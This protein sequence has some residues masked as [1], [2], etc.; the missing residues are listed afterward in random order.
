MELAWGF[1]QDTGI[2]LPAENPGT[3]ADPGVAVLPVEGQRAPGPELVQVRQGQRQLRPADR[4]GRLPVRQ[5]LDARPGGHR[6]DRP[7][8][9]LGHAAAAGP[10]LRGA[11]QRRHAVQPADRRGADQPDG[12]VVQQDHAAGGRAPAGLQV[13]RSP[14]SGSALAGRGHQRHRGGDVRRLPA[15]QG[16][17]GGQD[18][19]RPGSRQP[20]HLGV[21]LVR[22]VRPPQVRRGH[23]DPEL[24]FRRGRLR[25]GGPADLGRRSTA[26]RATRRRCRAATCPACR[27]LD[28]AGQLVPRQPGFGA[29]RRRPEPGKAGRRRPGA[30][31]AARRELGAAVQSRRR[32]YAAR[33]GRAR[34][35]AG[36]PRQGRRAATRRSG[37][38]TGCCS[39]RCSRSPCSGRC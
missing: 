10:G 22:A 8:L 9:R 26:W 24:R 11:G 13:A 38:P 21:R 29:G 17:R 27:T 23:D 6:L 35:S 4:V 39:P 34:V 31:Q 1:G 20:V 15:R 3:R 36:P 16:V 33:A 2:D 12:K 14:T 18:R 5:R 7:G 28:Q 32:R 30:G 37:R 25:A 19:Y